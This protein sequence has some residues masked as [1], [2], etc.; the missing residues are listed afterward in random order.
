MK[1]SVRY[2]RD[3]SWDGFS[4]SAGRWNGKNGKISSRDN[5]VGYVE[6]TPV[7]VSPSSSS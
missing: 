5:E 6:Q 7:L 4:V 3:R 2:E 1:V